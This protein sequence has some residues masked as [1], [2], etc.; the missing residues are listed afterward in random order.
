MSDQGEQRWT[1]STVQA[2]QNRPDV[3]APDE[4]VHQVT[5]IRNT[6]PDN[7]G[8]IIRG[9]HFKLLPPMVGA[10]MATVLTE[11]LIF[12]KASTQGHR[13]VAQDAQEK[14]SRH[15]L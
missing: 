4:H 15:T 12:T 5:F 8:Y 7:A 1:G 13:E 6:T 11:I 2:L 10:R 3:L 9:F 14:P